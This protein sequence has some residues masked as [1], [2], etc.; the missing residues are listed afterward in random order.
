[1]VPEFGEGQANVSAEVAKE[2]YERL[3]L[4]EQNKDTEP[5]ECML[6]MLK[7]FDGIRIYRLYES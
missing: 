6:A 7:M 4:A 2:N 5:M 1:M 3:D